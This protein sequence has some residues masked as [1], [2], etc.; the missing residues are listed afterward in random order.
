[1]QSVESLTS[2]VSVILFF[3]FALFLIFEHLARCVQY[4][5]TDNTIGVVFLLD[6]DGVHHVPAL[7][8]EHPVGE[9]QPAR[10]KLTAGQI[11]EKLGDHALLRLVNSAAGL[12]AE[13]QDD[14]QEL[15][16]LD[17]ARFIFVHALNQV[18]HIL[19]TFHEAEP[20]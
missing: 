17:L 15:I 19:Q 3:F 18:L 9:R 13:T 7:L 16:E 6:H 5:A 10:L 1:M 12:A 4:A 14:L 11:L 8:R 20:D 2:F